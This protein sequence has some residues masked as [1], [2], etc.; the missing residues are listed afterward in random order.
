MI[1]IPHAETH[2]NKIFEFDG[3]NQNSLD[4]WIRED[5]P[6]KE[7][8]KINVQ[9]NF[10]FYTWD[11]EK[12]NDNIRGGIKD[13]KGFSFFFARYAYSDE[14]KLIDES[15][16]T[17]GNPDYSSF[18]ASIP[19]GKILQLEVIKK[20]PNLGKRLDPA[21]FVLLI[22]NI[23]SKKEKTTIIS[24]TY[25]NKEEILLPY[26]ENRSKILIEKHDEEEKLTENGQ[27]W[28]KERLETLLEK[29]LYKRFMD[30]YKQFN[31]FLLE[32]QIK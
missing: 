16:V 2:Q 13:G 22:I 4:A 12:S 6:E 3:T 1:C 18:S 14:F 20:D 7:N 29:E 5:T 27:K 31:E 24:A 21:N 32:N 26:I 10:G 17:R 23:P 28:L 25:T 9:D 30:G 11:R 15:C 8:V 19:F